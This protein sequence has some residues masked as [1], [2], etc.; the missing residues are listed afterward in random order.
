[1]ESTSS[2]VAHFLFFTVANALVLN[3]TDTP[4]ISPR[5]ARLRGL[6]QAAWTARLQRSDLDTA[7]S[8]AAQE[9]YEQARD[10]LQD[11]GSTVVIADDGITLCGV[12]ELERR[13]GDDL[14]RQF[15]QL[16]SDT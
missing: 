1:M 3:S 16:L 10:D 8:S 12:S 7:E 13:Y 2:G 11:A 15:D 14:V 4:H 9:E 5:V 6:A